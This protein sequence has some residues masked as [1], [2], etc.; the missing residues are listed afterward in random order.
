MVIAQSASVE[1]V[2]SGKWLFSCYFVCH[3]ILECTLHIVNWRPV[4]SEIKS[5]YSWKRIQLFFCYNGSKWFSWVWA[6]LLTLLPSS[7]F[8]DGLPKSCAWGEPRGAR[9]FFFSFSASTSV[10]RMCCMTM[11]NSGSLFTFFSLYQR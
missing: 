2:L 10:F 7:Y 5:I 1:C 3:I 6:L 11:L 8:S 4:E 9:G